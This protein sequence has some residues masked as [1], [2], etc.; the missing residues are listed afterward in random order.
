[1]LLIPAVLSCAVAVLPLGHLV[2]MAAGANAGEMLDVLLRPRTLEL[3]GVTLALA[4]VVAAGSLAVGSGAAWLVERHDFP[5]RRVLALALALPLAVPSYVAAY[6]WL[7]AAPAVRGFWGAALVLTLCC[8]PYVYL[9]VAA[10]LRGLDPAWEEVAR[11]SGRG[12]W[13]AFR[14]VTVPQLRPAAAAGTLLVVTYV[15]ADFG[16]VSIM[17]VDTLTR[18]IATSMENSF[19]RLVPTTLSLLLVAVTG[20]VVLA[21]LRSR[22]RA[23][24]ARLGGGAGRRP[25]PRCLAGAARLAAPAALGL[26]LVAALGVPLASLGWWLT[27]GRSSDLDGSRLASAAVTT[28]GYAV[29]GMVLTLVLAL[30]VGLL[31]GRH[32]GR[33]ARA[34]EAGSWLPHAVPAIVVAL[35]LV[36]L[37]VRHAPAV[38]LS[39]ALLVLAYAILFLPLAVGA[40]RASAAQCP[41]V[42]EEAARSLGRSPSQVLR[43][44]T[45]PLAAPGIAAGALLV[46]L[47]GLKELTATLV[48]HPTGTETLAMRLWTTTGVG[49]YAAAAPY[50]ALIVLLAAVPGGLLVWWQGRRG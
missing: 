27:V 29:A 15:L 35:S 40:I 43:A 22:G 7:A 21:E 42:L 28:A 49:Q 26:V 2:A 44:V 23:R 32:A 41:P 6:T 20:I 24:F 9:P 34:L 19:T 50:A 37:S 1:M 36:Y 12:P 8:Y 11:S 30:P 4:A 25:R 18:S 31:A 46:L 10:A 48:L 38:Y 39:P 16:S 33:T 3:F 13:A 17:R 47:S 45:L 14:R 5:G